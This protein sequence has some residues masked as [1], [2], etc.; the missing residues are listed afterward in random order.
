M[1][2]SGSEYYIQQIQFLVSLYPLQLADGRSY[3]SIICPSPVV[4]SRSLGPTHEL[5]RTRRSAQGLS[6]KVDPQFGDERRTYMEV[7]LPVKMW[8]KETQSFLFLRLGCMKISRTA[9]TIP[10]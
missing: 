4:E 10:K 2:G 1:I 8:Y 3:D 6:A 7:L 9:E 5:E